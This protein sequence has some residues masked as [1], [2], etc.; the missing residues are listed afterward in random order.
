MKENHFSS[1]LLSVTRQ[2]NERATSSDRY[3]SQYRR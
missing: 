3:S 2:L 1:S